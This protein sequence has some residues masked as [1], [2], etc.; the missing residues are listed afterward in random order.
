MRLML[1]TPGNPSLLVTVE[2][3]YE[4]TYFKFTVI[5]G[6]W[7][8]AFTDG[9]ITVYGAPGGDFSILDTTEI[10]TANQ[11]RLRC[12]NGFYHDDGYEIVFA[13]FH[14]PDYV[15]PEH[16][17]VFFDDMDDDIPF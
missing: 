15:A 13:N 12:G 7:E 14:N 10:L 5:N 4:S 17:Q 2:D 6:G 11:D 16:K 3:D 1:G 9:H 8:G